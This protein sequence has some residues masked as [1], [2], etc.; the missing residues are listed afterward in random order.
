[1]SLDTHLSVSFNYPYVVLS[2]RQSSEN[3]DKLYR[4]DIKIITKGFVQRK[5]QISLVQ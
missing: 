1:M 5:V 3:L 4:C 2:S